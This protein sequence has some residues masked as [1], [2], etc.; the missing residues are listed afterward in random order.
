MKK[1]GK[2]FSIILLAYLFFCCKDVIKDKSK[3]IEFPT[4]NVSYSQHVGPLLQQK[5]ALSG[6]HTLHGIKPNLEYPSSYTSIL[7]YI[8][9]GNPE[10]SKLVQQLE[11]R[12]LPKMP[13]PNT[14]TLT[15][16][17]I[18]GIKTWIREGA[19]AN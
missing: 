15:S 6:C 3:E 8:I 7:D 16:N 13:P 9:T 5:C 4:T 14:T 11:G 18:E 2:L 12:L 17:Q 10:H 1:I 19:K